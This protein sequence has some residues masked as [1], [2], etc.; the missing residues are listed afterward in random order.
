MSIE[1][2]AYCDG[3]CNNKTKKAGGCGIVIQCQGFEKTYSFG[4]WINSTSARCELHGAIETLR[5][6]KNKT[7]KATIYC[8]NSYVVNC[9]AMGWLENWEAQGWFGRKNKDLLQ[10]FL[11]EIRLFPVGYVRF[12]WVK[13]HNKHRE[14][15]ICD[16]LAAEG[17][18]ST[19][20]ID[21]TEFFLTDS[22]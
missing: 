9:H 12:Q 11:A 13:G 6:I 8:D 4:Q 19:N 21:D 22:Q 5:L 14:N 2:K 18:K 10:Q 1:V 17:G 20:L 3:S 16:K 7:L 15:E